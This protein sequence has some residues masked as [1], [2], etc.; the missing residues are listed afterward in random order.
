MNRSIRSL[1]EDVVIAAVCSGW[2]FDE[3]FDFHIPHVKF[4]V[5]DVAAVKRR[6]LD[7]LLNDDT[8]DEIVQGEFMVLTEDGDFETDIDPDYAESIAALYKELSPGAEA[9]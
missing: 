7:F 2:S 1:A 3:S 6:V 4:K 8:L 9:S 5:D